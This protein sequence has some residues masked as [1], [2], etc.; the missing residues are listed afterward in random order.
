MKVLLIKLEGPE[1]SFGTVA[2]DETVPIQKFPALSMI[3]GLLANADGMCRTEN[4]K[5]QE[6]QNSMSIA[7]R[8][9]RAGHRFTEYQTASVNVKDKMWTSYGRSLGRD[10][11]KI[12]DPGGSFTIQMWKDFTCDAS[13]TVAITV[14]DIKK[15]EDKLENPIRPLFLGRK[16]FLP[17]RPIFLSV[18]EADNLL[19]AV[20]NAPID[21]DADQRM[22]L[23]WPAD[24]GE[25]YGYVKRIND[26]KSWYSNVHKG[27]RTV[28]EGFMEK[29]Q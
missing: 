2:V 18:V 19:E 21:L 9:D 17:S 11:G 8:I 15:Y 16:S 1:M 22:S 12:K 28:K 10:A 5:I 6:L 3:C 27:S 24:I 25:R 29:N 4:Q 14:P 20:E 23:Q 13:V 26:L 7:S